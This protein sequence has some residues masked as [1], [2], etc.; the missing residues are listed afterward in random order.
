MIMFTKAATLG[1]V[2]ISATVWLGYLLSMET[3]SSWGPALAPMAPPAA[4]AF[5]LVSFAALLARSASAFRQHLSGA[6]AALALAL[7]ILAFVL[8]IF[9]AVPGPSLPLARAFNPAGFAPSAAV[10]L[11]L[12][13]AALL[14]IDRSAWTAQWLAVGSLVIGFIGMMGYLYEADILYRLRDYATMS[15]PGALSILLL[16]SAI[17]TLR[18]H[19]GLMEAFTR[20]GPSQ[21]LARRFLPLAALAFIILHWFGRLGFRYDFYSPAIQSVMVST[22]GLLVIAFLTWQSIRQIQQADS[23]RSR[24]I[25]R[26]QIAASAARALIYEWE[27]LSGRV[28][29]VWGLESLT[30][31][32]RE[33]ADPT[34]VWWRGIVHPDDHERI[35]SSL[36]PSFH[37]GDTCRR[38]YR[39]RRKSGDYIHVEDTFVVLES[40]N[41]AIRRAIGSTVDVTER[42]QREEQLRVSN[43]DLRQFA[44]AAAHDLQEPIRSVT[45]FT[46]LLERALNNRLD[47]NSRLWMNHITGGGRRMQTLLRDFR[48]YAELA[49]LDAATVKQRGSAQTALSTALESLA[50]AAREAAAEITSDPL[51]DV[52]C[53]EPHLVQLFEN[54]IG[55]AIQYRGN[56]DPLRIHVSAVERPD[57]WMFSVSDNG[58]GIDPCYAQKIFGIFKQLARS[59]T[60]TG[61]GLAICAKVVERC[62][63]RIWVNSELGK[64][65]T[66]LF[67]L[68]RCL[69]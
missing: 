37:T 63:G 60:G 42:K 2:F 21:V 53:S 40:E 25:E 1:V 43:E 54:L 17:L 10:A 50:P 51:P 28:D 56:A 49:Q 30:G 4:I 14:L 31:F 68:P 57:E 48:I 62:G 22:A 67:T 16:S 8:P 29:R 26:F 3:L 46:E 36:P 12:L 6:L 44:Y 27:P 35:Y 52:A 18:P 11:V 66:F 47:S 19:H 32:S 13:C 23:L 59:E 69:A 9:D 7:C 64:G 33:E 65:A 61:M 5:P 45:L 15:L 41:G 55:N 34:D 58:I 38:E 39:L 20:P 24:A